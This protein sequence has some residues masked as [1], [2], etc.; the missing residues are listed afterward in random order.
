MIKQDKSRFGNR[1]KI[2]IKKSLCPFNP[3]IRPDLSNAL[4]KYVPADMVTGTEKHHVGH[5]LT[6]M[7]FMAYN[8]KNRKSTRQRLFERA[9][10]HLTLLREFVEARELDALIQSIQES[11]QTQYVRFSPDG[12]QPV[13]AV[14]LW[15][16]NNQRNILKLA[17][18]YHQ[19]AVFAGL[20]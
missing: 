18:H 4:S 8:V 7:S 5:V 16:V 3:C 1:S 11:L 14:G 2:D 13:Q 19:Q 20:L 6:F 15:L 9:I 12:E 17:E 10:H